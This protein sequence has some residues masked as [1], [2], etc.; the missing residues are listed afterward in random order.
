MC[1]TIGH[2]Y[3]WPSKLVLRAV[4]IL[5]QKFVER[6]KACEDHG[7]VHHLNDTLAEAIQVCSNANGASRDIRQSENF[8]VGLG[9]LTCNE[10]TSLQVLDSN[11]TLSRF[12]SLPDNGI[13]HK[14]LFAVDSLDVHVNS[15]IWQALQILLFQVEII[16]ALG[17]IIVCPFHLKKGLQLLSQTHARTTVACNVDSW[18]PFLTSIGR[19]LLEKD[20][21]INTERASFV[22][23]V[24]G[25]ENNIATF[26]IFGST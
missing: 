1:D 19:C 22:G 4:H 5:P 11:A 16:K 7:S 3:L 17:W 13:N 2:H 12:Q 10:S 25:N 8:V 24:V 6:G 15:V 9:G 26:R 14:V 18:Q 21:L 20:V 23:H